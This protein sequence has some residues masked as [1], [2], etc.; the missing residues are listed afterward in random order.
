MKKMVLCG[1]LALVALVT[2]SAG[3]KSE[4]RGKAAYSV[5]MTVQDLSNQ[6]WSSTCEELRKLI[7]ADGGSFTYIDCKSNPPTQIS[8]VENFISSGVDV[9]IVEPVEENSLN[10]VL[11]QAKDKGI[12]I[13]GWNAEGEN[14]NIRWIVD[15][16]ELGKV[17][18]KEA[19]KWINQKFNGSCEVAILDYPQ[20]GILL[21]RANGILAGL[22]EDA[23]NAKIVAQ[24]SA[25]NPIEGMAKTET[26]FQANPNIK[27]ICAIGGGGAVGANE[28]VKAA[29]KLTPDFGIFAADATNEELAAIKN[30]EACRMSVMITGGPTLMAKE[31]FDWVKKLLANEPVPERVYREMIPITAANLAQYAN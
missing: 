18:G 23:P 29:G 9:L 16:F 27:V 25:I 30:N 31:I 15:N 26:F 14:V 1:I 17:I 21:E 2:L 3:G 5:G 28:A 4:G 13:F 7:E 6:I 10:V 22:K 19:A 20:L 11:K 8:Q 12:K 24:S